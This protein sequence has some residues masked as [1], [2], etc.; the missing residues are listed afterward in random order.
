M[1]DIGSAF[2]I[3]IIGMLGVFCFL[4][5]LVGLMQLLGRWLP[6]SAADRRQS[7]RPTPASAPAGAPDHHLI[8]VLQA[9]VVAFED[10]N[11]RG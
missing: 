11:R 1:T 7:T 9:A 4:V 3:M 5:V 8:A 10:D 2:L 6:P